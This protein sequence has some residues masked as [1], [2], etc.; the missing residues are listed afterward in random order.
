M[1]ARTLVQQSRSTLLDPNQHLCWQGLWSNKV[2]QHCWIQT[3]TCASKDSHPTRSFNIAGSKPTLVLAR[4]LIQ[5]SRSTLL[6][7][8]Q[9]LCWQGLWSNKVVQ[10]CWIQI[11][12]CAGKD[13]G[14][15]RSFNIAGSKPTL[16]LA[17]TLIQQSRS[18]LLDQNQHLCWQ[19]L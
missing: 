2:V 9:H 4:T 14:P 19:G 15:T 18:T 17:R 8:N 5:Q 11:N 16:V 3:N 6:D 12:T 7:P 1:L 13:S 10:H